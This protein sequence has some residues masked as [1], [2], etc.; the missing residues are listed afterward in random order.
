MIRPSSI[1]IAEPIAVAGFPIKPSA[2]IQGL[3][4]ESCGVSSYS[5]NF[6]EEIVAV[7]SNEDIGHTDFMK[8]ASGR[9]AEILRTTLSNISEYGK[10]LAIAL[11]RG[12][13]NCYSRNELKDLATSRFSHRFV[14]LDDPFL[15]SPLFPT[16]VKD[17]NYT[18][19]NIS[20]GA[21]NTLEF[22]DPSEDQI[23]SFI[24]SNHADMIEVMKERDYSMCGAAWF[25]KDMETL[26]NTFVKAPSGNFDFSKVKD[27]TSERLIKAYVLLT[28]MYVSEDPVPWLKSGE[29]TK[30]REYVNY[31][32]NGMCLY[33]INLRKAINIF[34]ARELV[35]QEEGPVAFAD[36]RGDSKTRIIKAQV[37]VYFTNKALE[38]ITKDDCSMSE[39]ILGYY[40][41]KAQGNN[42]EV[43]SI[44]A[45][46]NFYQEKGNAYYTYVHSKLVAHSKD[47]FIEEA[48]KVIYNFVFNNKLIL[49]RVEAS[50]EQ[51]G[52]WI[53]ARFLGELERAYHNINKAHPNLG[54]VNDSNTPYTSLEDAIMGTRIVPVFLREIGCNLAADILEDT[55]LSLDKEDNVTDK[56]ERL[57]VALI[58]VIVDKCFE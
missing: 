39:V 43:S 7:T 9:F 48:Q 13:Q 10:P 6:R 32:W 12:V 26:A 21:L 11:A 25:L 38:V 49:E 29:L 20:L 50:G 28:K 2:I 24:N 23:R 18:Y 5:D 22:D 36:I 8:S 4:G 30:Y 19:T 40:W 42:A 3:D 31:L 45:N 44:L 46:P 35:I 47:R 57:H 33:L 52:S 54:S 34:R 14:A 27:I 37:T 15:D 1:A 56:K 17:K 55:Y 41:E 51:V 53:R 58:N 16:E